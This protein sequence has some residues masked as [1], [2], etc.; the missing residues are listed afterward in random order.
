M[1][2]TFLG[3]VCL[4]INVVRG[5]P[6]HEIGGGV[7]HGAVTASRLG[8]QARVIS[9]APAADRHHFAAIEQAGAALE[10]L[11]SPAS[12]SIR[13]D[14]PSDNPDDRISR[15]ISQAEPFTAAEVAGIEVRA[16]HVNP[17][18][19]GMV[20]PDL[21]PLLRPRVGLL[22]AD[23]QGFLRRVAPDGSAAHQPWPQ[24]A[25]YLHLLDLLKVDIVEAHTL[26]G[27][28][29]RFEAATALLGL[30]VGTVLLTH[31]QGVLA[32]RSTERHER[33]WG[34]WTLEGRTGRGDT[35]T[36]AFLV[37]TLQGL[38]LADALDLSARVTSAKMQYRGP[39][40]GDG[41]PPAASIR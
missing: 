27:L 14:Y 4:D 18:W 8:C 10:W 22:G 38:G 9:K 32:A 25:E 2:L 26:T 6:R 13:N 21:L 36:A 34:S 37:G 11:D 29:D 33:P 16:L 12:T 17:L 20:P 24:A 1:D 40:R 35:S 41:P 30:G 19:M 23:A 7:Y 3:D 39:Y 5:E 28:E 31:H 15:V